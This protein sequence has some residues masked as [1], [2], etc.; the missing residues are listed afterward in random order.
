MEKRKVFFNFHLTRHFSP[1]LFSALLWKN[2]LLWVSSP[3]CINERQRS[4]IYVLLDIYMD[5]NNFYIVEL[6]T[7]HLQLNI[8]LFISR[9]KMPSLMIMQKHN[10]SF[11]NLGEFSCD[12]L[13]AL[14]SGRL[15][16]KCEPWRKIYE[17]CLAYLFLQICRI[18]SP[19]TESLV[20]LKMLVDGFVL[21]IQ[22]SLLGMSMKQIKKKKN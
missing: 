19:C 3:H 20:M 7:D 17:H 10:W 11:L 4:H 15:D 22:I 21:G 1:T 2:M 6:V 9:M 18:L 13:I 16:L 8:S 12:L 14:F 5:K